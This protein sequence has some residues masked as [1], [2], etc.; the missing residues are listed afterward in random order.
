M[1][2]TQIFIKP[3]TVLGVQNSSEEKQIKKIK[4]KL[5]PMELTFQWRGKLMNNVYSMLE[6]GLRAKGRNRKQ[7]SWV[8]NSRGAE[9][10]VKV[11]PSRRT[12]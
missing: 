8:R 9:W 1:P 4:S 10:K 5:C 12:F 3:S 2:I 6:E 11:L 7:G